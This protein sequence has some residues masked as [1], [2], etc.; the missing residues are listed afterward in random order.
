MFSES[1]HIIYIKYVALERVLRLH[2][3]MSKDLFPDLQ[4]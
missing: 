1:N 2:V 4:E 3:K